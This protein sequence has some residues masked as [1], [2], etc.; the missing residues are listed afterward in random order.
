LTGALVQP[1]TEQVAIILR[2]SATVFVGLAESLNL[3]SFR[4]IAQTTITAIDAHSDQAVSIA[5][6]TQ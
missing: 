6:L 2:S 1:E 4:A 3:P 5:H